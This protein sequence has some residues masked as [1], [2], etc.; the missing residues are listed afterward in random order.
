MLLLPCA[1][2]RSVPQPLARQD[3]RCRYPRGTS[4]SKRLR[5]P[6]VCSSYMP[7]S[8]RPYEENATRES[9]FGAHV[10][11]ARPCRIRQQNCHI[12]CIAHEAS[13]ASTSPCSARIHNQLSKSRLTARTPAYRILLTRN[14]PGLGRYGLRIDYARTSCHKHSST[15]TNNRASRKSSREKKNKVADLSPACPPYY[16]NGYIVATDKQ[17]KGHHRRLPDR[18][19]SSTSGQRQHP[20]PQQCK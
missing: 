3:L 6:L 2:D 10:A 7:T 18:G 20:L 16:G 1:F 8:R 13:Y 12:V 9:G 19:P 11:S 5:G 14:R 17:P 15:T 4:D